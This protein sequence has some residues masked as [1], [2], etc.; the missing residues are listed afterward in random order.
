MPSPIIISGARVFA[1][2]VERYVDPELEE[3]PHLIYWE[4]ALDSLDDDGIMVGAAG[5]TPEAASSS[6]RA[7]LLA[8]QAA[9]EGA[10]GQLA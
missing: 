7:K 10:L 1:G 6:L 9:I 4:A 5:S 3:T 2:E 8:L